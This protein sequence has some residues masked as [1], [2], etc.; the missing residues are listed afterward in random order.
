MPTLIM[1]RADVLDWV[2]A[3]EQ[4]NW[5]KA[6][7]TALVPR[8]LV[9]FS[10][11]DVPSGITNPTP[12]LKFNI[13]KSYEAGHQMGVYIVRKSNGDD[14]WKFEETLTR[15]L[16]KWPVTDPTDRIGVYDSGD[17]G[18]KSFAIPPVPLWNEAIAKGT[19]TVK[20]QEVIPAGSKSSRI[21]SPISL[22]SGL[23]PYI[24][25]SYTGS[26]TT[27]DLAIYRSDI[28]FSTI[29]PTPGSQITIT[30]TVRNNGTQSTSN[31]LVEFWDGSPYDGGTLI[32][33]QTTGTIPGG[34]GTAS[35]SVAY[36]TSLGRHII[37]VRV[38]PTGSITELHRT[39]NFAF[40]S[41]WVLNNY[42]SYPTDFDANRPE[43]WVVDSDII[44]RATTSDV[45]PHPPQHASMV[46]G[47]PS[48]EAAHG[49]I[50]SQKLI[51]EGSHDDGS[52]WIVRPIP[53]AIPKNSSKTVRVDFWAKKA[54]SAWPNN[55]IIAAIDST[56]PEV[57][58]DFTM[59]DPPSSETWQS[60]SHSRV[61]TSGA[62]P[63]NMEVFVAVGFHNTETEN[64]DLA[65]YLDDILITVT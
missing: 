33:S 28:K 25:L 38:D 35:V 29:W 19:L 39:N 54:P 14:N 22:N 6:K 42:T 31:V 32:G 5:F 44:L 9:K 15:D 40:R 11:K 1:D 17:T 48:S 61:F 10:L 56:L 41:L 53:L 34:G 60:Y 37:Y 30:A 26:N 36:T 27:P 8:S 23:A 49:G 50:L 65:H 63:L 20:W 12:T 62:V 4:G 2:R 58:E 3:K 52:I 16:Y 57:E 45:L 55:T 64:L 46:G 21:A 51:Y 47:H 7:D 24:Q 43:E 59:L 18:L 13:E